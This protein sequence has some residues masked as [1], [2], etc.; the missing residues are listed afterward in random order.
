MEKKSMKKQIGSRKKW[1]LSWM[2]FS[3]LLIL[4]LIPVSYLCRPVS[5]E[6]EIVAGYYAEKSNTLDMVYIGGSSCL[7][8]WMP[9][10]AWKQYGI[11]SYNFAYSSIPADSLQATIKEAMKTQ[12][13]SLLVIDARPFQYR[14]ERTMQEVYVRNFTDSVPYS[15]NRTAYLCQT[16]PSKMDPSADHNIWNYLFDIAKY[17]GRWKQ[18]DQTSWEYSLNRHE[19]PYKGFYFIERQ[20]PVPKPN[21]AGIT[22]QISPSDETNHI[23]QSL[24]NYCKTLN[25]EI[26]FVVDPYSETE[27]HKMIYNYLEKEITSY[28]F[29]F[30]DAND[31]IEEMTL[32]YSTDFYNE[33][34]VN[35]FGAEKYTNFLGAYITEHYSLPDRRED[36]NY[37]SWQQGYKAW[38]QDLAEWQ[39]KINEIIAQGGTAPS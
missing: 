29:D 24:L 9:W 13:P 23:L 8:Y 5:P 10:E 31:Y 39:K 35:I 15:W 12:N 7:V 16:V 38:E 27:Q 33:S 26:L 2:L 1:M 11:V 28:G 6:R 18:L 36:A 32:D 20:W 3:V 4:I 22:E 17:H 19:N 21:C 30:L 25:C 34:H 14:D 37:T